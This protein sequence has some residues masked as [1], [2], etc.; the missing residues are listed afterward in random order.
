MEDFR[1]EALSHQMKYYKDNPQSESKPQGMVVIPTKTA[2]EDSIFVKLPTQQL[3][4]F[5][6]DYA[7]WSS[8]IDTF[9]S[10]VGKKDNISDTVK[11]SYLKA[12]VRG[13]AI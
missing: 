13:D 7:S 8:F 2:I 12:S 4:I 6:G 5:S 11:L 10:M 9:D 3:L 1:E